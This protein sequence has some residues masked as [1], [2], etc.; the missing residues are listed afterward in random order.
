MNKRK[1]IN[2]EE[3]KNYKKYKS[4]SI[5]ERLLEL[6]DDRIERELDMLIDVIGDMFNNILNVSNSF[7]VDQ[8]V[9]NMLDNGYIT[10][11][12]KL[13]ILKATSK[14]ITSDYLKTIS[15]LYGFADTYIK[16]NSVTKMVVI[17]FCLE[18]KKEKSEEY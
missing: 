3:G 11:R 13:S 5:C 8:K 16:Y 6:L 12:P 7:D 2:N 15:N 9:F 4:Q 18:S 10:I 17:T 14:A 1:D